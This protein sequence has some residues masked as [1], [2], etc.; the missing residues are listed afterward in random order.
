MSLR[1]A[2][3]TEGH[4]VA[5]YSDFKDLPD[6]A[7]GHAIALGNFDGLHAGHLAVIDAARVAGE[8]VGAPLGVATFEPP[9]RAFFQPGAPPFRLMRGPRRNMRLEAIGV[10][11]VYELAFNADMAAMTDEEFARDVLVEGLGIKHIAVGFD[12]RFGKGRMGDAESLK[13]LG[14]TLGFGVTIVEEVAADEVKASSSHVRE[15][16]KAGKPE[17]AAEI[18][19][20]A[21]VADGV[22]VKGEQRGTELGIPTANIHLG[23]LLH[24]KEGVYAVFV[25]IEG[26]DVWRGGVANFGRTPTTGLRDPLLETFIFDFDEDIYGKMLTV[27]FVKYLRPEKKFDSVEIMM[28][29]ILADIVTAQDVLSHAGQ[30]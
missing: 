11:S 25:Y 2:G 9:P 3:Q 24:P 8:A 5:V 22:V 6:E 23:E 27:A 21:W 14:E 26:D 16:L 18:L 12:Y 4:R 15:M 17:R 10:N 29:W 19:G 1:Q 7:R 13:A 28:E 20:E 30:D